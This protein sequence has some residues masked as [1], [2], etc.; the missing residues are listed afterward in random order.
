[1]TYKS[2]NNEA[3]LIH[4]YFGERRIT[5]LDAGANDGVTFSNS[6]DIIAR[7]GINEAYLFEPSS[8]CSKAK[9][10]HWDNLNVH[11]YNKGLG[12]KMAEVVFYESGAHVKGGSDRALVSTTDHA[13][14]I[15][16][17]KAGVEFTEKKVTI[18]DW[19][20]WYEWAGQPKIELISMDIEG[21]EW[22]LLQQMDLGVIGCEMLVIEFN[23][24]PGLAEKFIAYCD[25]FG[26]KEVSRN[27]ENIVFSLPQQHPDV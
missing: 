26:L 16:W 13:E 1:M 23:G 10:V 9:R 20:G 22:E 2:Q 27:G 4:I 17:R 19:S 15:R 18:L 21:G 24:K 5:L 25:K 12:A 11:I 14:T 3:S 6:Y 8:V 7:D